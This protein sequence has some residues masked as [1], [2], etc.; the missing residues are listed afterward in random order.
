MGEKFCHKVGLGFD[1]SFLEKTIVNLIESGIC[2]RSE[3]GV[4]GGLVFPMFMSGRVVAQEFFWW[5]EDGKGRD[6]LEA[7]EL[8]AKE[9]GAESIIM[10]SLAKSDYNRVGD[11]YK[12]RG[13]SLLE[14]NYIKDI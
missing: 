2:L 12:K 13:Y 14:S 3:K 9:M 10:V 7:F 5:S 11:I 8:K 1:K 6:L 4:V